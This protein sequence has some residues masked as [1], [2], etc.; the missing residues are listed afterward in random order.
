MGEQ[1][2]LERLISGNRPARRMLDVGEKEA[3]MKRVWAGKK[4]GM[5]GK[6]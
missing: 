3:G 1:T 5:A 6:R 2:K 4:G